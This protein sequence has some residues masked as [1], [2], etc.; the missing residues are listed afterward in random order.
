[1]AFA[2][3]L[4]MP[5]RL[6]EVLIAM[7][8][9]RPKL[10]ADLLDGALGVNVPAFHRADVSSGDLNDIAPTEYRADLVIT[11]TTHDK[12]VL[13][14]VVE[15]QLRADRRKR[16]SWPAYVAT[17]YSRLGCPVALLVVCH[18]L[19]SPYGARCRSPSAR[20]LCWLHLWSA[21]TTFLS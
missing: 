6:H 14:V 17:L 5:S 15:A 3:V 2:S 12:P 7:F 9:G 13:A 8:R 16:R 19:V 4:L 11:F 10:A 21:Q 20:A 18:R 1:M